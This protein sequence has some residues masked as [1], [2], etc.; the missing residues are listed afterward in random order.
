MTFHQHKF[1]AAGER[2]GDRLVGG[3]GSSIAEKLVDERG[4]QNRVGI[5]FG[6]NQF[7][8]TASCQFICISVYLLQLD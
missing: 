2:K 1:A 5:W 8:E 6:G 3:L 4:G 7:R